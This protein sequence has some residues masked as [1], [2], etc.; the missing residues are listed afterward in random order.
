MNRSLHFI[1]DSLAA[2]T[3]D[4]MRGDLD[5]N[6]AGGLDPEETGWTLQGFGMLRK[7]LAGGKY[8]LH[9][10][11]SRYRV[12]NVTM[13]H[14]H[15]WDF[16]SLVIAGQIDQ[17]RYQR[18]QPVPDHHANVVPVMEQSIVCGPGGGVCEKP[19][20]MTLYRGPLEV[21]PAGSTYTQLAC[22]VHESLPLDGTVTLI[23]RTFHENTE[24]AHVYYD[25]G[26][27]W[28]TAEPRPATCEEVADILERSLRAWFDTEPERVLLELDGDAP[29]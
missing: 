17:Y 1:R 26:S 13:L 12:E 4:I 9:V 22:E 2:L 28:V 20:P 23:E 6:A 19:A 5:L 3:E 27:E 29:C 7:Y 10:W 16:D 18:N 24:V 14:D 25:Q 21:I 11:D 8:R 15:P